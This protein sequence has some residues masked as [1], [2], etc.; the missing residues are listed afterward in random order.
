[1]SWF[2]DLVAI[3]MEA[4]NQSSPGALAALLLVAALTE[5]GV[6][7][8][9]VI[10][11]VLFITSYQSGLWSIQVLYV[12]VALLV[13]R[14]LGAAVIFW[15]SRFLGNVFINWMEKHFPALHGKLMG[16]CGRLGKRAVP[17]VAIAR[18]TPGL[19]TPSSVAAGA[20]YMRY[21]YFMLGIVLA[22]LIADGAL[23]A[24]GFAA[25][26]GLEY[27]G[28]TPSG[29]EVVGVLLVLV[30][31]A[32]GVRYLWRRRTRVEERHE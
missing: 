15:L 1:M 25:R 26:H 29:W 23:I 27:L 4:V 30:L 19:L 16:L 32:L 21:G 14:E 7:F 10:D 24:F 3:A 13:G 18:L 2:N 17:A 31:L 9:F 5:V 20:I 28:F 22:S 12:I 6:P 11:G 8:P